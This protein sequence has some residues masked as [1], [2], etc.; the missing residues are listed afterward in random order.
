MVPALHFQLPWLGGLGRG[1]SAPGPGPKPPEAPASHLLPPPAWQASDPS[2]QEL[3]P[4][5]QG[6]YRALPA[7]RASGLPLAAARRLLIPPRGGLRPDQ[8]PPVWPLEAAC[9]RRDR[10][11]LG[12]ACC[13]PGAF[14]APPGRA[15]DGRPALLSARLLSSFRSR[16]H[17]RGCLGAQAA[18][19]RLPAPSEEGFENPTRVPAPRSLSGGASRHRR[20]C[21]PLLGATFCLP[22]GCW[23][24]GCWPV[25][26][27]LALGEWWVPVCELLVWVACHPSS[28]W[29]LSLVELGSRDSGLQTR[30]LS[31][32]C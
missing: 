14:A 6:S 5:S 16:P 32:H 22:V 28:L 10:P 21:P 3:R 7:A 24:P 17:A 23:L 15:T 25:C 1:G 18:V 29:L 11:P 30:P 9:C 2:R 13:A 26:G 19:L 31:H 8:R 4:E 12:S 20:R 27:H